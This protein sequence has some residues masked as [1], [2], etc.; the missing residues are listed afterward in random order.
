MYI[1]LKLP[2]EIINI[3]TKTILAAVSDYFR[4]IFESRLAMKKTL[5]PP[6]PINSAITTKPY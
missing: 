6:P 1:K 3:T 5:P 2:R 4:R